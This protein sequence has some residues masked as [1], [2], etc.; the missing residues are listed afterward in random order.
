[1]AGTTETSGKP[2]R[3]VKRLTATERK[4]KTIDEI[5]GNIAAVL[6]KLVN[7]AEGFVNSGNRDAAKRTLDVWQE[8]LDLNVPPAAPDGQ[9]PAS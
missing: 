2:K 7:V 1:M 3:T 9:S 4:A 5:D 6:G 8:V